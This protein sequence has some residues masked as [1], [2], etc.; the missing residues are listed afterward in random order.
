MTNAGREL[1]EQYVY[2]KV[3][4]IK[5][6][7]LLGLIWVLPM[8]VFVFKTKTYY[9]DKKGWKKDLRDGAIIISNHKTFM[10]GVV[11]A[12][13]TRL[14]RMHFLAMDFYGDSRRFLRGLV[15][16][17][18]GIFVS[19]KGDDLDF[20]AK[21]KDVLGK[22]RPLLMFPEGDFN[23]GLEPA[24]FS[25]GYIVLAARMG[26]KIVPIVNDFNY[27]LFKRV[28]LLVGRSIDLSGY[29][30][31]E[32]KGEG[33]K[34]INDELRK[35]YLMLFYKLKKL[36]AEKFSNNYSFISPKMGD[37]I[38]INAGNYHHYGI[39]LNANE[40]IQFG[41]SINRPGEDVLIN[42]VSMKDFCGSDI[43]EVRV[44][45][46]REKRHV[47]SPQDIARYAR[48]SLGRGDYGIMDNNCLDFAHRVVLKI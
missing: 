28:H 36:K 15:I 42:S 44:F 2:R 13:K 41:H 26:A 6:L 45:R 48:L 46:R 29:P 21:A 5:F 11:I 32:M 7:Y 47:R 9:E 25:P 19:E 35:K 31:S 1:S 23:F 17:A 37:I 43:P 24:M 33:L 40:V 8:Q 12:F 4:M 16:L 10:D 30:I 38:R 34:Q 18:G 39:Y 22:G 27:G 14:N 20:I 3:G